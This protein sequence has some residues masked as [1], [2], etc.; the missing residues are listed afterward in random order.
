MNDFYIY[1]LEQANFFIKEGVSVVEVGRGKKNDF[2]I[3]FLRNSL[4]NLVFDKWI[5]NK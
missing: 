5:N 3:K 4:S 1:N 2:Y